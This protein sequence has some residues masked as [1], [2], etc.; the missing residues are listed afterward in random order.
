M[1][2][3]D[4]STSSSDPS[5]VEENV[6]LSTSPGLH[7]TSG[8]DKEDPD[9]GDGL[10]DPD[11]PNSKSDTTN[12]SSEG[13]LVEHPV[14]AYQEPRTL[15]HG[16]RGARDPD[17]SGIFVN[18]D[19][20]MQEN[21]DGD[22]GSKEDAFV[23]APDDLGFVEGRTSDG[24]EES[25]ALIEIGENTVDKQ[26]VVEVNR[27]RSLLSN[28]L[29]ECRRYK[30]EHESLGKEIDSIQYQL[31]VMIV[32]RSPNNEGIV[33]NIQLPNMSGD[34][35]TN[36]KSIHSKLH[37]CSGLAS[38]LGAV[39]CSKDQAIDDLNGKLLENLVSHDVVS[40]YMSSLRNEQLEY[41]QGSYDAF[42]KRLSVSLAPVIQ[43]NVIIQDSANDEASIVENKMHLLIDRYSWFYYYIEQL[44]DC[45]SRVGSKFAVPQGEEVGVIFQATQN[46]LL[47]SKTNETYY[48]EKIN[49]F[50]QDKVK[51]NEQLDKMKENLEEAKSKPAK[52]RRNLNTWNKGLL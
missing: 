48:I 35:G 34:F 21:V 39:L 42:V 49:D 19:G 31:K 17:E 7:Q 52:P 24:L 33:E 50:K 9:V 37:Q 25:I 44:R 6:L 16:H 5:S 46:E 10:A 12:S 26:L 47:E 32:Q 23:D 8:P 36:Q 2:A 27:L 18:I 15:P 45:L 4:G 28:S 3:E 20:S 22:D 11:S 1:S 30:G 13:V 51:M 38:H 41:L 40:S 29:D 14:N 43:D